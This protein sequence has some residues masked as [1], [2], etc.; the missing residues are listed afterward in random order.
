VRALQARAR[1]GDAQAHHAL[2]LALATGRGIARDTD[3]AM[4]HL[5]QAARLGNAKGQHALGQEIY[6][7]DHARA[8]RLFRQSA[9]GGSA[10]G[11]LA[12]GT[13]LFNGRHTKRN[14]REGLA[15]L[16]RA[17]AADPPAPGAAAEL[18]AALTRVAADQRTDR[19]NLELAIR[20]VG[21]AGASAA[22]LR[23]ARPSL[24]LVPSRVSD[25]RIPIGRTKIGGAPDLPRAH[26]WPRRN[27]GRPLAFLAQLAL[28]DVPDELRRALPAR[29]VLSFFYDAAQ[30]PWGSVGEEDA[31]AVFLFDGRAR[32]RR[33]ALEDRARQKPARACSVT[34][35]SE[36]TI[37]VA[38]T[39]LARSLAPGDAFTRYVE[40]ERRFSCDY[41]R[42][43]FADGEVH[44]AFGH[45]DA[46]QGDLGRRVAY[47]LAG[48]DLDTPTPRLE[49]AA[50]Q[51][52]LL[53]Q[54]DS[55]TCFDRMWG[56]LGRIYF[57][58][59]EPDLAAG[60]FDRVF[61]QL[62]CT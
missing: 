53:L 40:L 30:Q 36:L 48:A 14:E 12:A 33:T 11:A 56:D 38:R 9:R 7:E 24:R 23:A 17:A 4:A 47:G 21:L 60:R 28:A 25:T 49:K 19:Q 39:A 10:D 16:R 59:R 34:T 18:E 13:M 20:E 43:P 22:I 46:I 31:W 26:A 27:D 32:L 50:G 57:L 45:A 42:Y 44:R 15:L 55:D 8:L 58:I 1:R 41:R 51:W 37:P 62:Q 29:A 54:L 5:E 52:R 6:G 61:L 3:A 2:Y 35:F